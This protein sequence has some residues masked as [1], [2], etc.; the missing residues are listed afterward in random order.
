MNHSPGATALLITERI[1]GLQQ[2]LREMGQNDLDE[3]LA[4]L[5]ALAEFSSIVEQRYQTQC[6][7]QADAVVQAA[8]VISE[9]YETKEELKRARFQSEALI[10]AISNILISMDNEG[11][12]TRWNAVAVDVFGISSEDAIGTKFDELDIKWR[13]WAALE[14]AIQNCPARLSM[15]D[16]CQFED[17][18][19]SLRTLAVSTFPILAHSDSIAKLILASDITMQ[20]AMQV[21]LDQAQRLEAVGQLAAGVAHE[22]N[23]PMQYIGD[24]V[25]YVYK[26]IRNLSPVLDCLPDL[27]DPEICD[28]Q[29]CNLRR[30]ILGSFKPPK[31]KKML[32]QIQEALSDSQEGVASVSRIVAAMKEFSHPG[33]DKMSLVDLDH[34]LDSTITVAKNEWK[35]VAEVEKNYEA[36]LPKVEGLAGELN[37]VFLNLIVNASHAIADRVAEGRYEKGLIKITARSLNDCVVVTIE[38]NGGGIPK[39]FQ[40]R[41][42]EPFF[43]TKEVGKGTGQGLPLAYSIVTKKHSGSLTFD[44]TEGLGTTFAVQLPCRM[45]AL[46][47]STHDT[48]ILC[49]Q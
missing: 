31:I 9:L 5:E 37:Q 38:D 47:P 11:I 8:D 17:R 48:A 32:T 14:D 18:N 39:E 44:V 41:V 35:Y 46:P 40:D 22:I 1:D 36:N 12:V 4:R 27:V 26:A 15:G 34:I 33:G 13:N 21:Q 16:N 20:R 30:P 42:F 29:I 2:T 10:N 7:A 45:P 28:E 23:T 6:K 19:G 49:L 24:N 25:R 43:T 3:V